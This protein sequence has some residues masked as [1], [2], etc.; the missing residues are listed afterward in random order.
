MCNGCL[1]YPTLLNLTLVWINNCTKDLK[2]PWY[3]MVWSRPH[4]RL[5]AIELQTQKLHAW[6]SC[7]AFFS[8]KQKYN[9]SWDMLNPEGSTWWSLCGSVGER[10]HLSAAF[11]GALKLGHAAATHS[12]FHC[13]LPIETQLVSLSLF[14]SGLCPVFRPCNFQHLFSC[15]SPVFNHP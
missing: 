15:V 7:L 8:D 3:E 13:S 12:V 6:C 14:T 10:W 9:E 11:E 2:C 1:A 5:L 4:S